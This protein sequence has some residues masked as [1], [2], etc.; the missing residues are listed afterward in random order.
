MVKQNTPKG[1][2][3]R[4]LAR[5]EKEQG[6]QRTITWIAVGV[7]VVVVLLS[8]YALG[9]VVFQSQKKMAKVGNVTIISSDFQRRQRYERR[10]IESQ[11]DQYQTSLGE[12]QSQSTEGLEY[13]VEQYQV[14]LS[15]LQ[16]QISADN[17]E[18]FAKGILDRMV[19]EELVRQEAAARGIVVSED[20]VDLQIEQILGYD[21][22]AASA[23]VTETTTTTTTTTPPMTKEEY[24][25]AYKRF[26]ANI[27]AAG[28]SEADYRDIIKAGLLQPKLLDIVSADVKSVEDQVETVVFITG[29]AESALTFQTRLNN[30]EVTTETLISELNGDTSAAS[31]AYPLPW[32][33]MGYLGGQVGP[34]VERAAFNTPVGKASEPVMGLDGNYYVIYVGAHEEHELSDSML[35]DARQEQYISWVE[36]QKE[37]RVEYF[38][39]QEAIVAATVQ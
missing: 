13:W 34:D 24:N 17:T 7:I 28:I 14:Q 21:R 10:L 39:W 4:Q 12:M 30:G 11:I 33:P 35:E 19:E 31:G 27:T 38:N 16:L 23:P 26:E 25:A 32:L 1:L 5:H 37:S 36:T 3:R 15:Q 22:E 18:N 29:T 20:E 9:G 8:A 6:M 2:T